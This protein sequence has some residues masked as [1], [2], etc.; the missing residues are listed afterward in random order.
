MKTRYVDIAVYI[1][2]SIYRY[3]YV[4]LIAFRVENI[5]ANRSIGVYIDV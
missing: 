1:H 3:R 5:L 4:N 2:G